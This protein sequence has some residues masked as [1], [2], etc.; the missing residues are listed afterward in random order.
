MCAN[1]N[2][3]SNPWFALGGFI[4]RHMV[5]VAPL[6]VFI[7]VMFPQAEALTPAVELMFAFMTFQNA[8]ATTARELWGVVRRPLPL[9]VALAVLL[10]VMPLV[11]FGAGRALFGTQPDVIAGMVIEYCVP[12]GV[13]GLMWTQIYNGNRSF[14]LAVVVVSTV[15]VPLTLPLSLELLLGATVELDVAGMMLDLLTMVALPAVAGI[16]CNDLSRGKANARVNPWLAP[17]AKLMLVV[18]LVVNST[19]IS[20]AMRHLT[21]SLVAIAAVMAC[22]GALGYALGYVAGRLL[23]LG[24]GDCLTMG[25]TTGARNITSGAVLAAAYFPD[26]TM[27]PVIMGTLFQH[28]IAGLFGWAVRRLDHRCTPAPAPTPTP[29]APAQVESG[30]ETDAPD[31]SQTPLRK[32]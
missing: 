18:I 31:V 14:A 5:V 23:G 12:M 25:I 9:L 7:G 16:A 15:L 4:G 27:F 21:W 22:L 11:S 28:V 6:C 24:V 19:H 1:A 8:M 13:T 17:A 32:P 20:S 2:A 30:R 26:A 10:V 3:T 29:A